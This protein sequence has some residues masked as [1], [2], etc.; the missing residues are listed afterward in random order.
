MA[1]ASATGRKT[2]LPTTAPCARIMVVSGKAIAQARSSL[3]SFA[4]VRP[5][6]FAVRVRVCRASKP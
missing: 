5:V 1:E 3:A 2:V 4:L 6:C